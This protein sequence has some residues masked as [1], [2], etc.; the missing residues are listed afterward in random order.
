MFSISSG[1]PQRDSIRRAARCQ[2]SCSSWRVTAQFP[3]FASVAQ[4]ETRT[5]RAKLLRAQWR[6]LFRLKP[7]SHS[8]K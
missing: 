4:I 7:P 2:D 6:T 3:A 5:T 1:E 8:S